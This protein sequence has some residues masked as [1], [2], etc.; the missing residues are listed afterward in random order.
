MIDEAAR[1]LD[2][3]V[4]RRPREIDVAT[5]MGMGFPPFRGGLLRYADSLGIPFIISKLEEIYSLPGPKREVSSYLRQ[6]SENGR[7]FYSSGKDSGDN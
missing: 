3:K 7:S 1:C 6:L 2:E 4:V 5:V